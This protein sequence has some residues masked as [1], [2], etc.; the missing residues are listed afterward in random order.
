MLT[1]NELRQSDLFVEAIKRQIS[2]FPKQL[3]YCSVRAATEGPK[4]LFCIV[5]AGVPQR[6]GKSELL[7]Y[8]KFQLHSE[9]FPQ[10]ELISRLKELNTSCKFPAGKGELSF[11][12]K[13]CF[14]SEYFHR[15]GSHYHEW[16]GHLYDLGIS[17]S[18]LV[19]SEPL[20]AVA[21]QNHDLP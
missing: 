21:R 5:R 10:S 20:V 14:P 17:Q 13:N 15:S 4:T 12:L 11:E 19:S 8:G 16:P 7:Q 6:G 1:D 9:I 3:Q 2:L 18:N